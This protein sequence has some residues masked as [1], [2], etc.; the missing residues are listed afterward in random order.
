MGLGNTTGA[1]P[2]ANGGTGVTSAA[3]IRNM[4]GL[5]NTTGVL[6]IANGGTGANSVA[7]AQN[8]L[9]L[10]SILQC[11]QLYYSYDLGWSVYVAHGF[12]WAYAY[13]PATGDGSWDRKDCPYVIPEQYRLKILGHVTAPVLTNNGGSWTGAIVVTS[14][15]TITVKN[16]G[17][18]GSADARYGFVCYPI[19]A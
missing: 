18:V 5:G 7:M 15:G 4:L 1:L 9:G 11:E 10:S 2:V 13:G 3:A 12:V 14:D 16:L 8:A 17:N 6:P 19:G